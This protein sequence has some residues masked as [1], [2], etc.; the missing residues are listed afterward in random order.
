MPRWDLIE[1]PGPE[2]T[3]A[4]AKAEWSRQ[5]SRY[6]LSS[7]M[8]RILRARNPAESESALNDAVLHL[9]VLALGSE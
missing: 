1:D 8:K 5:R 3:D 4:S 2:P 9:G 7:S 6:L